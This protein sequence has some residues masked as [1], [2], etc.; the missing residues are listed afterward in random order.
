MNQIRADN[1]IT[2]A[3]NDILQAPADSPTAQ[4]KGNCQPRASFL[5]HDMQMIIP[6]IR[7]FHVGDIAKTLL[8][9]N[10]PEMC[11]ERR[12]VAA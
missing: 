12:E 9:A 8:R 11:I 3:L 5:L 2:A 1:V 4:R 6:D 10:L 7:E